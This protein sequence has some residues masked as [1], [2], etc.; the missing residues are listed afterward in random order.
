[1]TEEL[2]ERFPILS[3]NVKTLPCTLTEEDFNTQA[4]DLAE[5]CQEIL[6][7]EARQADTKAQLKA[8]MT[9]LEACRN[10]LAIVVARREEMRRVQTQTYADLDKGQA[11]EVRTDN[12]KVLASRPLTD[13]ERQQHLPL[14]DEN[15]QGSDPLPF[16]P[17]LVHSADPAANVDPGQQPTDPEHA[18]L[19]AQQAAEAQSPDASGAVDPMVV[20]DPLGDP[21]A[22]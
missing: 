14:N 20:R 12:M 8:R 10:C 11:I 9:Q 2:T 15:A 19:D 22:E 21:L 7:E 16:A 5:A 4:K 18:A 3:R 17:R 1:M 13:N 6:A